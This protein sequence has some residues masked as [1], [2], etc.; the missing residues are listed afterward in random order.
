MDLPGTHNYRFRKS[1]VIVVISR[2]M[3]HPMSRLAA[4][5]RLFP[6]YLVRIF[7]NLLEMTCVPHTL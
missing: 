7:A 5:G 4:S 6:T 1:R 2:I 3:C